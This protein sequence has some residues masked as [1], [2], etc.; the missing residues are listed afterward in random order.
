MK[1]LIYENQLFI[2][3]PI[4]ITNGLYELREAS[5]AVVDKMVEQHHY[6][7]KAT[8]NRFISFLV[9]KDKG[10]L[11]LGYG[12]RPH[13]K[14]TI[15][16]YITT[17]NYC[18]F[19]RMWLSDELPK[20]SE[21]QV[22][23]LLLSYLKQAYPRIKFVITYA[24]GSVGN[25]GIIYKA[26][27]AFSVGKVNLDF[28]LLPDGERVH[29]VTMWHRHKSRAWSL[30]RALYPGIKHITDDYQYRYL[31]VLNRRLRKLVFKELGRLS[32][33]SDT[34]CTQQGRGGAVPPACSFS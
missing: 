2:K 29:P 20:F 13:M 11:Q 14:H 5:N 21:S 18:E 1:N 23:S 28:Y 33:K 8:Q 31:Y 25:T 32:I 9:N 24:D 3:K 22:I 4:G 17:E 27:S 19:D 34:P 16:Q 12:I 6:S 10:F 26:T 15:S 7:G 30:M